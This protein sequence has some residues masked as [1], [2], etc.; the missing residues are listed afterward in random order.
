MGTTGHVPVKLR[1]LLLVAI[2]LATALLGYFI[3]Y[4]PPQAGDTTKAAAHPRMYPPS[5]A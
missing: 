3:F 2:S 1:E 5:Y 4:C